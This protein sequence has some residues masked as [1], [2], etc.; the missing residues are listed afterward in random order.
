MRTSPILTESE[1]YRQGLEN[2]DVW[3]ECDLDVLVEV[4]NNEDA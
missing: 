4:S 1:E 2:S 3:S